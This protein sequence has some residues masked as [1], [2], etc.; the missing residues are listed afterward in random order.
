MQ[1]NKQTNKTKNQKKPKKNKKQKKTIHQN[2]AASTAQKYC[3]KNFKITDH[4]Y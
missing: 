1:T 3:Y 2:S 4:K